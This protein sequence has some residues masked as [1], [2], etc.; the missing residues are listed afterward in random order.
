[1]LLAAI[2][3]AVRGAGRGTRGTSLPSTPARRA[4]VRAA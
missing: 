4:V 2:V 1:L 3:N